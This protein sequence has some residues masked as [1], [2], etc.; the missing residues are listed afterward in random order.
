MSKEGW[1]EHSSEGEQRGQRPRSWRQ[2]GK[3][4]GGPAWDA[5]SGGREKWEKGPGWALPTAL[6]HLEA[7]R[8]TR[9]LPPQ[10]QEAVTQKTHQ[11]RREQRPEAVSLFLLPR[12]ARAGRLGRWQV[13]LATPRTALRWAERSWGSWVLLP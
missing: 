12:Q 3:D 9:D 11:K 5:H 8:G 2:C 6:S 7:G 10:A 13:V 1:E 4:V